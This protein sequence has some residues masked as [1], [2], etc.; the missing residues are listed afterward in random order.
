M[1]VE[2]FILIA[3]IPILK[4][5]IVKKSTYFRVLFNN[6]VCLYKKF[7][8]I[9]SFKFAAKLFLWLRPKW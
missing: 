3:W 7:F 4:I 2:M 6:I 9:F 5:I 1:T 8:L